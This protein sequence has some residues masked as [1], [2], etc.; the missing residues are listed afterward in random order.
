MSAYPQLGW[1]SERDETSVI[2]RPMEKQITRAKPKAPSRIA[3]G[4]KSQAWAEPCWIK[5]AK[6][7]IDAS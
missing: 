4:M 3:L 1:E 7:V 2:A 5:S 6:E